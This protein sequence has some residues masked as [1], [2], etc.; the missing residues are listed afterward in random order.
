M[1]LVKGMGNPTPIKGNAPITIS[2][3]CLKRCPDNPINN[4]PRNSV[5]IGLVLVLGLGGG[6]V[7]KGSCPDSGGIV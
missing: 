1:S 6:G 7:S 3:H 2:F 4:N 5:R